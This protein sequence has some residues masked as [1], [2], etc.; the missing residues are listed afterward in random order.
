[1]SDTYH[2]INLHV[3]FSTKDRLPLIRDELR[4]E[5]FAYMGGVASNRESV[6]LH[7]GG[8]EDHVHL[9]I[10]VPPKFAPSDLLRD[11]KANSSRW[12]KDE[13]EING[14]SWQDGFSVFSVSPSKVDAT[15]AY[16]DSQRD[17]HAK[18]S[19][20][21]ELRDMYDAHGIPYDERFMPPVR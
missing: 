9:L 5:M 14:F 15:K 16:L 17:H 4:D 2:S 19:Y 8:V 3:V 1:M 18:V 7:A 10:G 13:W 12:L 20:G 11:M 6:L 21:R